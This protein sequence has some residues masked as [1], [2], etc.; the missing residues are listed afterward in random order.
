[1]EEDSDWLTT[2]GTI[3]FGREATEETKEKIPYPLLYWNDAT[4]ERYFTLFHPIRIKE[5]CSEQEMYRAIQDEW[6]N[7]GISFEKNKYSLITL[8]TQYEDKMCTSHAATLVELDNGYLLFEKTNPESPY[9]ATK[10][11]TLE[12]VKNYLYEMLRLE[13]SRYDSEVGT[14]VILQDDKLL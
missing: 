12:G 11:S 14:Y 6:K 1:M 7:R 9:A 3:I 2:D 10:F 13:N 8:W 5:G 4:I